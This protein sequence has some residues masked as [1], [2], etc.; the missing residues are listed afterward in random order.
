MFGDVSYSANQILQERVFDRWWYKRAVVR[1]NQLQLPGNLPLAEVAHYLNNGFREGKVNL[2]ARGLAY[3][4]LMALPPLLIFLFTLLAYFPMKEVQDMLLT[5]LQGF[6]PDSN[7]QLASEFIDDLLIQKHSSWMSISFLFTIVL[8]VNG[9]SKCIQS[10]NY[11]R[12]TSTRLGTAKRYMVCIVLVFLLFVLMVVAM[13]LIVG[14]EHIAAYL[15]DHNWIADSKISR[16]LMQLGRWVI[17]L[18]LTLFVLTA[19]YKSA[20]PKKQ[21]KRMGF[22]SVGS[23]IATLLFFALTWGFEIYVD[24]FNKFNL[25]YG[26]IGSILIMMLWIYLNCL[27]ML[28]GYEVNMCVMRSHLD[29]AQW[30]KIRKRMRKSIRARRDKALRINPEPQDKSDKPKQPQT[31]WATLKVD[32]V[33]RKNADGNWEAVESNINNTL[34]NNN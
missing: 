5:Q 18:M 10:M 30:R 13:A 14:Y 32:L 21:R 16:G 7:Y 1:Y 27:V 34:K 23:I 19:I 33:L 25:L 6:I 12:D 2:R 3:S 22:F 15:M 17:L 4:L 9:L 8:A 11:N 24:N 29:A 20:L 31:E 28:V 26:S